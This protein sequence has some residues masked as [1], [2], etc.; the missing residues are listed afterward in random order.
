MPQLAAVQPED[1]EHGQVAAA[2]ADRDG[3]RVGDGQDG[4][5]ARA[6]PPAP[7]EGRRRRASRST[8]PGGE[9]VTSDDRVGEVGLD[10]LATLVPG[11][12]VTA[13]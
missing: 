8:S 10:G 13:R 7:A 1:P 5:D 12:V 11:A 4:D 3:R 6:S 9:G 2:G